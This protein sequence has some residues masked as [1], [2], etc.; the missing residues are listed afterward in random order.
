MF[1]ALPTLQYI[2]WTE[3]NNELCEITK[4]HVH[5]SLYLYKKPSYT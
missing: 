4:T 2:F 5:F 1:Y 3:V